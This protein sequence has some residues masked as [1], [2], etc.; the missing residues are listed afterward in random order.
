MAR[1]RRFIMTTQGEKVRYK[2]AEDSLQLKYV[3]PAVEDH[4]MEIE[5]LAPAL[6]HLAAAIKRTGEIVD[7]TSTP[8]STHIKASSEGSFIIDMVIQAG[9]LEGL[10]N[11]AKAFALGDETQAVKTMLEIGAMAVTSL[12][13][14][15]NE[16]LEEDLNLD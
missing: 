14:F 1:R 6:L 3:G 11:D 4:T 12:V 7:P 10:W 5:T 15:A 2:A 9:I 8:L 16:S 13:A